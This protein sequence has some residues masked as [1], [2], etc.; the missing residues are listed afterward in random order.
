MKWTQLLFA[1]LLFLSN[2]AIATG[3]GFSQI[4]LKDNPDR[5]LDTAIWYPTQEESNTTEIGAN[6]VFVGTHVIP[7]AQIQ[8]GTFPVVLLSHGYRGNWRNQNWLASKLAKRGYIVAALN[9]PGTTSLDHS[10]K[11]AAKWWERPRDMS[12]VLDYLFTASRWKKHARTANVTAIGHSLGGWTVMQLA[13]ARIDRT[14]F[15]ANCLKYPNPKTCGLAKELGLSTVQALEPSSKELRDPR[16]KRIVSLDLGL[17]RSFSV[18]SLRGINLPLLIL[19]AGVD[20]GDLPQATESGYIAEHVPLN[21]RRYKVY[22]NAAHFSFIQL[23]K[24]GAEVL[25][26][27]EVPGDGII[28]TDGINASRSQLHQLMF[29]DIIGFIER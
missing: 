9:H 25:L 2:T 11:Q 18:N 17:A 27:D 7:G 6:P 28:C 5:P 16:I 10:S 19:A 8:S 15:E 29:N 1:S 12:R 3:I 13:G 14:T 20:I 26:E 24:P 23:C 22:E 4:T 21:S